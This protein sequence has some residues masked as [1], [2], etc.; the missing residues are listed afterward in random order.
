MCDRFQ[1]DSTATSNGKQTDNLQAIGFDKYN[2]VVT[3]GVCMALKACNGGD[4][5]P[6]VF[7]LND[8]GGKVMTESIN[9]TN[10]I[11]PDK[12]QKQP[13]VMVLNDQGGAFM[14]VSNN[15]VGTLRAQMDGHPPVV[16]V[17]KP[18]YTLKI[19]GGARRWRKGSIDTD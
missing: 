19:R 7:V 13:C 4:D 1:M 14:N 9:Q 6:V 2:Q 10:A 5:Y 18:V 11:K 16:M 3:G 12:M 17:E 8:Q 15:V